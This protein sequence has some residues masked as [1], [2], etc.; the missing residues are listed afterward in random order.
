MIL[1]E[2]V[3]LGAMIL[4]SYKDLLVAAARQAD[5]AVI[6]VELSEQWY[7]IKVH[8]VP[9]RHYLTCRLTLAYEEVE[10]STEYQPKRNLTWLWSSKELQSGNQK[11]SSAIITLD[12]LEEARGFLSTAFDLED[13][14]TGQSNTGKQG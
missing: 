4:P 2:K 12:S 7:H 1:L 5:P 3:A 9:I 13:P 11:G 14:G 10:L 6:S 8:R